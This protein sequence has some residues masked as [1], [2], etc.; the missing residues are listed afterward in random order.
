M[1]IQQVCKIK[2]IILCTALRGRSQKKN[3]EIQFHD[4]TS[5]DCEKFSLSYDDNMSG[6]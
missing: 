6:F 2:K 1:N 4:D 3:R 5:A